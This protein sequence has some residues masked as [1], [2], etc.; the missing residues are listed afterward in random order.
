MIMQVLLS[1]QTQIMVAE[2]YFNEPG[3]EHE[4]SNTE[5]RA[6]SLRT[7][8]GLRL[9]TLRHAINDLLQEEALLAQWPELKGV[10]VQHFSG[11]RRH[12]L[13]EVK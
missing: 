5:A 2:P 1:I 7:N 3:M 8:Q 6:R 11:I 12:I 4:R 10:L 13:Q 9:D